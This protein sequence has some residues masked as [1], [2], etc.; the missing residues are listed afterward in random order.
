MLRNDFE[1]KI[2][3]KLLGGQQKPL[4][5]RSIFG[6]QLS[7]FSVGDPFK[8]CTQANLGGPWKPGKAAVQTLLTFNKWELVKPLASVD[9]TMASFR[10]SDCFPHNSGTAIN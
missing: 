10:K 8:N 7:R 4:A 1:D 3:F 6:T 9:L 5:K 2:R